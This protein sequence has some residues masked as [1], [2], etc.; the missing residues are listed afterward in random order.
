MN[1]KEMLEHCA[2]LQRDNP[3]FTE[4]FLELQKQGKVGVIDA[5]GMGNIPV[6]FANGLSLAEA[7][8]NSLI[9][10]WTKGIFVRTQYDDR[11][12]SGDYIHPPSKDSTMITVIQAPLSEP[13][14][15]REFPGG[16]DALE[17]YRQEMLDG[18]KDGWIRD[19]TN[20]ADKRWEYTYHERIFKYKIPG[21]ENTINQFKLMTENLAR[22]P[23][24]RRAQVVTWQP[25]E[26]A[27]ISDPACLQSI[28]GRILRDNPQAQFA[29]YSDEQTGKPKLNLNW[30]FRSRDAY[31]AAFMNNFALI[32]FGQMMTAEIS[33]IRGEEVILGRSVDISDSYHIYGKDYE[34]FLNRFGRSL[35]TRHFLETEDYDSNARTWRSDS[36]VVVASFEEARKMIPGKIAEQDAKYA[37]KEGLTKG[38]SKLLGK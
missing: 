11:N 32:D 9:T 5:V 21:L 7:W 34:T 14:I 23:I 22:G 28:W 6:L 2:E 20:P 4:K 36:P 8:E 13:R 33:R 12:S 1:E 30:R 27:V 19:K 37:R 10:L 3:I 17:E 29:M 25:W 35:A 26:D 18:I 31:G 24:T 16:L 38:S 15:H